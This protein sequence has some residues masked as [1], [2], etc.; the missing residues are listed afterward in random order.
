MSGYL[1]MMSSVGIA[2]DPSVDKET[3]VWVRRQVGR[4]GGGGGG[5]DVFFFFFFCMACTTFLDHII[6]AVHGHLVWCCVNKP[7]KCF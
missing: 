7:Y 2:I 4:G 3:I 1:R 5:L 6:S